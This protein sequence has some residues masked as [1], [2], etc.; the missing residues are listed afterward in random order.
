[1]VKARRK[2]VSGVA[3]SIRVADL[4]TSVPCLLSVISNHHRL[5]CTY[6]EIS[7]EATCMNLTPLETPVLSVD[8]RD[9]RRDSHVFG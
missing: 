7:P 2:I 4:T 1:M 9:N 6:Q 3:L 8:A 5:K